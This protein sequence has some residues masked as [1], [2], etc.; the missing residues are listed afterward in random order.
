[1]CNICVCAFVTY[2]K[3]TVLTYCQQYILPIKLLQ[4]TF[5][6]NTAFPSNNI[7]LGFCL[8]D[9]FLHHHH[10]LMLHPYKYYIII[11]I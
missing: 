1:M 11:L 6:S 8:T 4:A 7:S 10:R 2:N 9:L 5:T 3:T